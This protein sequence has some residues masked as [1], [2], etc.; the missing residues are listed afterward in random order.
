M[1][2]Y[3]CVGVCRGEECGERRGSGEHLL[4]FGNT[5]I[6][7]GIPVYISHGIE[8]CLITL[9]AQK[10]I[11]DVHFSIQRLSMGCVQY[12]NYV[13]GSGISSPLT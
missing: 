2:E 8:F 7:V 5:N 9:A 11:E 4:V 3:V 10:P 12:I 6:L 13:G 1:C